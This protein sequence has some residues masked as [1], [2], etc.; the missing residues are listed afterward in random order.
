M[1]FAWEGYTVDTYTANE[2]I[3]TSQTTT[4]PRIT[5]VVI[6]N[7]LPIIFIDMLQATYHQ[8]GTGISSAF[9]VKLITTMKCESSH[10]L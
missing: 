2:T 10:F 8:L 3:L 1:D 6:Q 9:L 7:T 4:I 5:T